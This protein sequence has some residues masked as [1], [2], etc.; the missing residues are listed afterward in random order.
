MALQDDINAF[1]VANT[2]QDYLLLVAQT[3]NTTTNRSISV[4]NTASLPDLSLSTVDP[5][6]VVFVES[7][8]IPVVAQ[9]GCWTGLDNRELRNDADL[10]LAYGWGCNCVG[11]MGDGTKTNTASPVPV[12]GGFIDWCQVSAGYSHTVALRQNGT[13]WAWGEN[14]FG[15]LGDETTVAKCSPIS[16]IGGFTDW[17]QVSAGTQHSLGVRT[18]GSLWAW[19]SNVGGRLGDGTETSR[20]SPVSVLGGFT[21]WCQASAGFYHSVAV[22]QNGSLWAWGQNNRFGFLGLGVLGDGTTTNRSS[23][24]SVIGG[25]TDWCQVSA[26]RYTTVAIRSNCTLWAW[27]CGAGGRLGN[28]TTSNA[29]SPVSVVGG[30]TDWC[31]VSTMTASSNHTLAQRTDGSLWSWGYNAQGQLGDGTT[32]AKCSP[33]SVVG[34]FTNWCC[35]STGSSFSAGVRT[36]GTLWTWGNNQ[37]CQLGTGNNTCFSSPVSVIGGFTDWTKVALGNFTAN[38]IRS[39]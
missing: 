35:V 33:V 32:V 38:A 15:K 19:G 4:A 23:P 7:L 34:G 28:G 27:G 10:A 36:N 21:D 12:I 22:R 25:F 8:G 24:I 2:V 14:C 30:F 1:N 31:R 18:N 5:G 6:T 3:A 9:L 20:S 17:C 26:G 29:L 13:L 16:V 39:A 37:G 11:Q